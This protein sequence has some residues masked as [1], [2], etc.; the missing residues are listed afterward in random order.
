MNLMI[1]LTIPDTISAMFG[2][3]CCRKRVGRHRSLS[4]GFGEK[5]FHTKPMKDPFYGEWEIGTYSAPWRVIQDNLLVCGSLEDVESIDELDAQIQIIE[6]GNISSVEMISCFDLRVILENNTYVEFLQV[7]TGE[8]ELVHI[9]GPN[10]LYC[11][12]AINAGW[13]IGRSDV[14]WT[15]D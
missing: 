8:D 13:K 6:F 3:P 4:L 5:V 2:Q 12:Y 11:E 10:S 7:A 9:F 15:Q 1:D 14:P